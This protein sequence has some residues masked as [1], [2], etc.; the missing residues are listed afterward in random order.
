MAG[1]SEPSVDIDILMEFPDS[2]IL[3]SRPESQD[4]YQT[5]HKFLIGNGPIKDGS[6]NPEYVTEAL[7]VITLP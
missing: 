6:K 4:H 1:V 3:I 5:F 2:R 7:A